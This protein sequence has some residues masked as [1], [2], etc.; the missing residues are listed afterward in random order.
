MKLSRIL[1][2][3]LA[4]ST[5]HVF[6]ADEAATTAAAN[7]Q[8]TATTIQQIAPE[9][10]KTGWTA[11]YLNETRYG[12]ADAASITGGTM[13]LYHQATLG[14]KF[15]AGKFTLN[16]AWVQKHAVVNYTETFTSTDTWLKWSFNKINMNHDW[17]LASSVR[18]YLP[19]SAASKAISSNGT[20]RADLS[21]KRPLNDRFA[22][23]FDS[24]HYQRFQTQVSSLTQ[25]SQLAAVSPKVQSKFGVPDSLKGSMS[26]K[27]NQQYRSYNLLGLEYEMS[28]KWSFEQHVGYQNVVTHADASSQIGSRNEDTLEIWSYFN[29]SPAPGVDFQLGLEQSRGSAD[30]AADE[31]FNLFADNETNYFL[32]VSLGI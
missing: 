20:A 5:G 4:L 25:D 30:R 28:K 24:I 26:F 3:V 8:T 27:A 12:R 6:A 18:Y 22:F 13:E 10:P 32:S 9:A 7:A 17:S 11:T 1:M 21:F 31:S 29:Y 16:Q 15:A 14:Y 19:T 23:V 2:C